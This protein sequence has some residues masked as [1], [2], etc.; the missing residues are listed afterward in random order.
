[1]P[2]LS[3]A[4]EIADLEGLVAAARSVA[5]RLPPLAL[6]VADQIEAQVATLKALKKKQR[7]YMAEQKVTTEALHAVIDRGTVTAREIRTYVVLV[8]G[9]K[10]GRLTQFGIQVRRRPR[11]KAAE[12]QPATRD[13][14]RTA[15]TARAK[16]ADDRGA[17]Q[18]IGA[19]TGQVR[20]EAGPIGGNTAALR[21]KPFGAW[22]LAQPVGTFPDR[23]GAE[24]SGDRGNT[25]GLRGTATSAGGNPLTNAA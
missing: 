24:G 22:G 7:A 2:K 16:T 21:G 20:G 3:Y 19:D 12:A 15:P 17:V 6:T 23:V 25:H 5:D 10:H 11:R 13:A 4:Q 1:M 18:E 9:K 8:Y 14:A